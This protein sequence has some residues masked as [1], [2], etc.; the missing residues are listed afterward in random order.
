[1]NFSRSGTRVISS[2]KNALSNSSSRDVGTKLTV[3][4]LGLHHS[5]LDRTGFTH[6]SNGNGF[7]PLPEDGID[8]DALEEHYIRE[9]CQRSEGNETRA[10]RLLKMNYYAYRY[11]KKKIDKV[12]SAY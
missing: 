9:A 2:C 5:V 11:R 7:P 4:D 1:M 12:D 10:A 8:L 6:P 3:N